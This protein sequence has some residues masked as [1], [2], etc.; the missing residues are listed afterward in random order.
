MR[1]GSVDSKKVLDIKNKLYEEIKETYGD[2]PW[3]DALILSHQSNSFI[4]AI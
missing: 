1:E 4:L 2:D 3:W